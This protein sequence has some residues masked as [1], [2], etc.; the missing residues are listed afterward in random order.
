MHASDSIATYI[1]YAQI[2]SLAYIFCSLITYR[3]L[4]LTVA[5]SSVVGHGTMERYVSHAVI[6]I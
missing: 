4:Q 1:N 6:I 5:F 2:L 3:V